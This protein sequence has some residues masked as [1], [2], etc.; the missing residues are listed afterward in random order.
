M[1][2]YIHINKYIFSNEY[3]HI[4]EVPSPVLELRGGGEKPG[5]LG[6]SGATSTIYQ[7]Q[8]VY[9]YIAGP[10]TLFVLDLQSSL[11]CNWTVDPIRVHSQMSSK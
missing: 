5:L 11:P 3:I 8:D 10:L 9:I 2:I 7:L 1:H 6:K 4:R